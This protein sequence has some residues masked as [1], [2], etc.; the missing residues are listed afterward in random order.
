MDSESQNPK[1][2]WWRGPGKMSLDE[3]GQ[4]YRFFRLIPHKGSE[5]AIANSNT[6]AKTLN[7]VP[8]IPETPIPGENNT[9][10]RISLA[11]SVWHAIHGIGG[12]VNASLDDTKNSPEIREDIGGHC[13]M[14]HIYGIKDVPPGHMTTEQIAHLVPDAMSTG[15]SWATQPI[16]MEHLGQIGGDFNPHTGDYDLWA[17]RRPS[18]IQKTEKD[19][20]I[21]I[22]SVAPFKNGKA[23]FGRRGDTNTWNFPG[24]HVEDGET[25]I[26]AAVRELLEET[27]LKPTSLRSLGSKVITGKSGKELEV[28]SY[29]A[30]VDGIPDASRDPDKEF[31]EFKWIDPY[32]PDEDVMQKL[33]NKPDVTIEL[34]KDL[35]KTFEGL[36]KA[37]L[38]PTHGYI[39]DHDADDDGITVK[40]HLN[41]VPVAE[42][43]LVHHPRL[44]RLYPLMVDVDPDHRRR[45]LA[46]AMYAYAEKV[47]GRKIIP[48]A[49]QTEDGKALW[50]GNQKQV[51]FG[52]IRKDEGYEHELGEWLA[53]MHPGFTF[54]KLGLPDN[55]RETPIVDDPR[56]ME[57]YR[58]AQ[59]NEAM[60]RIKEHDELRGEAREKKRTELRSMP[61][62]TVG[63]AS[64]LG[65]MI[66]HSKGDLLRLDAIS[67]GGLNRIRYGHNNAPLATQLHEDLHLMFS[68]VQN[69]YGPESRRNLARNIVERMKL[70]EP[71][72]YKALNM[73]MGS[74]GYIPT[75]P[76]YQ[77]E[78]LTGLLSYLNNPGER[79]AFHAQHGHDP[80]FQRNFSTLLK[81][82]YELVR[83][84]SRNEINTRWLLRPDQK[85]KLDWDDFEAEYQAADTGLA[86][87]SLADIKNGRKL[88][89]SRHAL[90]E[91]RYDYNH[92][93]SPEQ[94]TAGYKLQVHENG[95]TGVRA[96][97]YHPSEASAHNRLGPG[98][99]GT[100]GAT[101]GN[102]N[103]IYL[104]Y[105]YVLEHH[106]GGKGVPM[107]EALMAHAKNHMGIVSV[108]GDEHS[109]M[110]AAVHQKLAQKH[111]LDYKPVLN[112]PEYAGKSP[113][114]HDDRY[115]G[116]SYM[117][118]SE[119]N[120]QDDLAVDTAT[121]M[122]GFNPQVHPAFSAAMFLSGKPEVSYQTIRQALYDQ[123]DYVDAALQAYGL[124]MDDANRAAVKAVMSISGLSKAEVEQI[125]AGKDIV[126]GTSDAD[127]TAEGIRRVFRSGHVRAA[128]LNGKHS[129]GSLIARD[130]ISD[131]IYLL[132][133]GAG[134]QSPAAGASQEPAT[135]S[136]RE[137]AFW[138]VMEDVGLGESV[139]RADLVIIDGREYAVIHMLPFTWKG[140][141]KKLNSDHMIGRRVFGAYRDRGILHKW[142][143]IDFVLG[144]P[145]RHGD[146]MMI[147]DDD[148]LLALIDHGSAFAG[149]SFDPA[150]D[151][152][153]F[154]P[155]YLRAWAGEKF[156][157]LSV[158]EKLAKM[159]TLDAQLRDEL[160]TW[161]DD[162]HADHLA[163][164]LTRFGI[165]PQPSLDRLAKVKTLAM[166]MPVD[167]AINRLW[168]TV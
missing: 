163:G 39:I 110:A 117:L 42:A 131:K 30:T 18:R 103:N 147:S 51:Q 142:A 4:G 135:Q 111:G 73:F 119:D 29:R 24:G 151:K 35:K 76:Y 1:S 144:N 41:G 124:G 93:L 83:G 116:Y 94:R 74:R 31:V 37:V 14:F 138:H 112:D 157:R 71:E 28:H 67:G 165:D 23:L 95:G 107:Y 57:I 82:G 43:E 17:F 158:K 145:D 128:H 7:E 40:A 53:K 105:A 79:M 137:V 121:D 109:S 3:V 139:P 126:A 92:L 8:R 80:E 20:L 86:K 106:R 64:T 26:K 21:Q 99:A 148:Q 34:L 97:L 13:H 130:E 68:R 50:A 132:K 10:P 159:P 150:N 44:Q 155:F 11:P 161:L 90:N 70:A 59:T 120:L 25:P 125:P 98:E 66:S 49:D 12:G 115:A 77:E 96:V 6:G 45:G 9:I 78:H 122:I 133:P 65:G 123:E 58:R 84:L 101:V 153:S 36:G 168:V 149:P 160:R 152:N 38:D 85:A 19:G 108:D 127:Q 60:T 72:T 143:V 61:D 46:S 52:T 54:P 48:S 100:V 27:G 154:V 140:F 114:P 2:E 162:I 15:E 33:S 118:K 56:Q 55:R 5:Y 146:N 22:V 88:K 89:S 136:R 129:K 69:K 134:G 164:L 62:D 81:K 32:H 104:N 156:N 16:Q 63:E 141:Q 47:T 113:G 167:E 166:Q 75:H 91:K 87:M 102:R